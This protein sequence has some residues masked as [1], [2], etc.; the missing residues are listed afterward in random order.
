MGEDGINTNVGNAGGQL[1][2]GQKQRIAIARAFIKKP[3]ILLLDEAT[4]A[5]D[6]RNENEVQ[7]AI[8]KISQELGSITTIVIAHRLSSIINSDK[9]IVMHKGKIIEIGNHQTLLQ[10]YPE[11]TYAKFVK[12]QE[13]SEDRKQ[14]LD[15]QGDEPQITE[16][17]EQ[18]K[19]ARLSEES[20]Q[21][22]ILDKEEQEMKT[23]Q[24]DVDKIEDDEFEAFKKE[25]A[26]KNNFM[27]LVKISQPRVNILIGLFV[28]MCQGMIMPW[29]G[30]LLAKMLF[31]LN[32]YYVPLGNDVRSDSNMYCLQIL[33][34]ALIS[35]F[36]GFMQKLC[37]GVIG[38]NV[39]L[40]IREGQYSSVLQ[41]H[42]GYFDQKENAPGV[43]SASM[44]CDAQIINGV[45]AEGL[46][47]SLEAAFAILSGVVIGFFF[48]WKISLACLACVPFMIVASIMNAQFQAGMSSDSDSASKEANLLA[49]DVII[50][51]RTVAS[52][53]NEDQILNDYKKLLDGPLKI[54]ARK[55]HVIGVIFGFSQFVQYAVFAVLY[56]VGAVIIQNNF[57]NKELDKD[58]PD[59]VFIAI[60]TMMFGAMAAGQAQQ[61]GPDIGKAK[62]ASAKVFG[63][64]DIPS[65]INAINQPGSDLIKINSQTFKG[66]IEFKNVWF[67]YPTR[68]NDWI[69]KGLN[70]KINSKETVALVGE[71]GCGKSTIV[72]LLLRFYDVNSGLILLD[73]QD[74]K[75]YEL[76][77]LRQAI[78]LV[79]QEPTLF[80]YTVLENILYGQD[81]ASNSDIR[82]AAEVANALEFI[83]TQE[84]NNALDDSA[85]SLITK[86][87]ENQKIVVSVLGENEYNE[88]LG[89]LEDLKKDEIK[90]GKFLAQQ[91]DID[92][93]VEDKKDIQLHNGFTVDCG[94]RGC[95]L[96]G[97]QKQRIAIARA[98][99]RKPK[100]LILDE[101]TSALDEASQRQVQVALDNIMKNRTSIVIAHRLSTVEKCDR[102]LVLE[103]G[104]LVEEGGFQEL[105]QKDGGKFAQ[106][107]SGMQNPKSKNQ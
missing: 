26:K 76:K 66:E 86:F 88:A 79:M 39:T 33:I 104:R 47:S 58:K 87:K 69:L 91:G 32:Y 93:R 49:G 8:D 52:F 59:E 18:V 24:D 96:S 60:F 5:L 37:F 45:S 80:N 48:N 56:Y 50:N 3:K 84:L 16:K 106:L 107:A 99:I 29:F 20:K 9:I 78:G 71:S 10:N 83:E 53:G 25:L 63:M 101:A 81:Q 13:Q 12:E 17:N 6:K 95:K 11:G 77:S 7:G 38:E 61:F 14:E 27:R 82:A 28:S 64:M 23:K 19:E 15:V 72:S 36:T 41:K 51:Y 102:V 34:A 100:M 4:S 42:I 98:I 92:R 90:Q 94:L 35:F 75:N 2:G 46:A 54:A 85:E 40:K 57:D 103:S 97:G 89:L 70:M 30:I 67:R 21:Q 62:A 74:I 1:S 43:I 65:K 44:A 31:V 55:N 22:L 105:S 73:G 68:K